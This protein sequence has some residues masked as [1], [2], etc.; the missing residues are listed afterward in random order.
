MKT[1]LLIVLTFLFCINLNAQTTFAAIQNIDP[2]TGDEAYEI[3]HGDLDNDG[4]MDIVMATYFYN[5][6]TPTQDYI[7][8][9][10]NDGSGTFTIET[11]V[12]TS[13]R[14][15][16]GLTVADLDGVNGDDIIATSVNQNKIVYFLSD[17]VGGFGPEIAVD[18]S[19]NGPGEVVAGDI[20][21]DGYNDI[22]SVSYGDNKTVW[23]SNDGSANFTMETDIENGSTDGPYYVDIGDFDFDGDLDVL[24]GFFNTGAIEIFY[25]QYI[26][27][28]TM[29]VSWIKDTTP[30]ETSST[31]LFGI[32]FA[33][34]DNNNDNDGDNN[35]GDH[36]LEIVKL[37]FSAGTVEWFDKIKNGASTSTVICDDTII[38]NPGA[39]F[40]ADIDGDTYNDVIVTDGGVADDALIW[41]KGAL[42]STPNSTP[43]TIINNNYQMYDLTI[44]NFDA[45]VT[46]DT[47]LDIATIGNSSDTVDWFENELSPTLNTTDLTKPEIR[48]YPNPTSSILYIDGIE[49][50][51]NVSI[52]NALGQEVIIAET[53]NNSINVSNLSQGIYYLQSSDKKLTYKFSK[54]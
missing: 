15:V 10:S 18:S 11:E 33:D 14:W 8:W 29:T 39:F 49:E 35:D 37:D 7:K 50:N 17:G 21:N 20:N 51:I 31:Y 5:G 34:V 13:I 52:F 16:D 30:V 2:N 9:Y 46:G 38:N 53:V 47:D 36:D 3:A 22:I 43:T 1:Y 44:A 25:N 32:G 12:S 28:G 24:V 6:G 27:S 4:D 19:I 45:D 48:F 23:Y 26:E 40:V 54:Q 41:F 42:N